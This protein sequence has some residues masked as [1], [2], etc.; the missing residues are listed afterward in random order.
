MGSKASWCDIGL[1][2]TT[3][4]TLD[5]QR[6]EISS[7]RLCL[8]VTG[9]GSLAQLTQC[10]VHDSE[11]ERCVVVDEGAAA[12]LDRCK[13][14]QAVGSFG[15]STLGQG[16]TLTAADSQLGFAGCFDGAVVRVVSGARAELKGA[17]HVQ[18]GFGREGDELETALLAV[19]EGSVVQLLGSGVTVQG[20][21]AGDLGGR[22]ERV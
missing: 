14:W 16:T 2:A 12:A 11:G 17:T 21:E 10:H 7:C 9:A 15:I 19:H 8:C 3:G 13:V 18:V 4:A 20:Q 6:C 5:A 1:V 22:V